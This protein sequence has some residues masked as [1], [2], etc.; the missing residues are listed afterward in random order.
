M[1]WSGAP[2]LSAMLVP[3]EN[4]RPHPHNPR[5]GNVEQIAEMLAEYG[6][7]KPIVADPD[8]LVIAGNHV[9]RA[10]TERLGWDT[11]A[12]VYA[13]LTADQALAFMVG[14][15]RVTDIASYD[16]A[17]HARVLDE[18]AASSTNVRTA[19]FV[20]DDELRRVL[21]DA[22][23]LAHRDRPAKATLTCGHCGHRWEA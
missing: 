14:D 11:I 23:R 16:D 19:G 17:L 4:L 18:L 20:S 10:A 7:L 6:Q 8:G 9:L 3:V 22:N 5:R 15:N 2:E 13:D 1:T 12:V 21:A